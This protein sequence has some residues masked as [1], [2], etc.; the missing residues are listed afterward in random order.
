MNKKIIFI[1]LLNCILSQSL[2]AAQR[3]SSS[4]NKLQELMEFPF[5]NGVSDYKGERDISDKCAFYNPAT[6]TLSMGEG[7]VADIKEEHLPM[8]KEILSRVKE[9]YGWFCFYEAQ[10]HENAKSLKVYQKS[11]DEAQRQKDIH[12]T[13]KFIMDYQRALDK[14]RYEND[15]QRKAQKLRAQLKKNDIKQWSSEWLA[16]CSN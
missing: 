15:E 10:A 6:R 3:Y 14:S 1:C 11:I 9:A 4:D 8:V 2:F 5:L 7:R 16:K 12:K 13:E